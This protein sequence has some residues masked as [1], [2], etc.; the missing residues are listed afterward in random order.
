MAVLP[1]GRKEKSTNE[2]KLEIP[3]KNIIL[4]SKSPRRQQLLR[5]LGLHFTTQSLD[6][7]ESFPNDLDPS[8]VAEYLA[9]KKAKA[10]LPYLY[11][12][13]LL[14]T[15]DTTVLAG[16]AILNKPGNEAEAMEMLESIQGKTHKV[17]TGVCIMDLEHQI[18]FS[19]CTEVSFSHLDTFEIKHYINAFKPF[20]KAGGYGIQEWIGLI[21]INSIHGSYYTVMGL[22]VHK[23]YAYLKSNYDLKY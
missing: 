18:L 4:A 22:P 15:A 17:I 21:G 8:R 9:E 13:D 12:K 23:I 16:S 10:F 1:N 6:T 20:D 2:T 3:D 14:I 11:D 19:D 5:D 7:D